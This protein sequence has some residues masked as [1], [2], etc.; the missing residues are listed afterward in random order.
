[1]NEAERAI[2]LVN[3]ASGFSPQVAIGLLTVAGWLTGW[4]IC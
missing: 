3:L 1:M 4:L 2:E